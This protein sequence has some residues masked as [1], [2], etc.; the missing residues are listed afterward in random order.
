M[1]FHCQEAT[2]CKSW[3]LEQE[4]YNFSNIC[5]TITVNVTLNPQCCHQLAA[6]L[7]GSAS[8]WINEVTLCCT[9]LVLGRVTVC[10]RVNHLSLQPATHANSA[11]YTQW[12]NDITAATLWGEVCAKQVLSMRVGPFAFRYQ[13]NRAT[14]ANILIPLEKQ[15]IVLQLCRWE[16]LYN[17]TSQ[18]TFR[19]LL[20]KLSKRRQISILRKLGAV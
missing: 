17:E 7:S 15:L 11:F 16:F 5:C 4:V 10:A 12:R 9:Q 20:P 6:W 18:Q 13:G 14:P 1:V 8:I 19:P 2:L 3:R